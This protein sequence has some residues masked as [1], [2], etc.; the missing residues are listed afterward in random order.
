MTPS[1]V[2]VKTIVSDTFRFFCL[3]GLEGSGHHYLLGAS[4]AVFRANSDLPRIGKQLDLKPFYLPYAMGGSASHYAEAETEA[5]KGMKRLG[6]EAAGLPL[7]TFYFPN[8]AL[9]YPQ[10]AGPDKVMQYNDLKM[11]AKE[12]ESAD[13]DMRV[14][15]LKRSAH[16]IIVA[17]TVHRDFHT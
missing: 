10:F 15:Y 7:P 6:K 14:V 16:D 2:V 11:M 17:N 1:G 9:S 5:R 4:S 12:A 8:Q 13:L 3:A